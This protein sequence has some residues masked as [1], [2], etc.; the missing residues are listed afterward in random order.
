MLR[1]V[2]RQVPFARTGYRAIRCFGVGSARLAVSLIL[3]TI[4]RSAWLRGMAFDALKQDLVLAP[5]PESF[6]VS[7]RDK[8]IGRDIYANAEFDFAK[9]RTAIR[10]A[11]LSD[12]N[13]DLLFVDIGANIGPI[14]IPVI[15]RGLAARALAIEPEPLNRKL[16][17]ANAILNDVSDRIEVFP[18]A[19]GAAPG[20][21][22]FELSDRNFGDH[23]IRSKV[24]ASEDRYREAE[25]DTVEVEMTTLDRVLEPETAPNVLLWLDTQGYEGFVLKGATATLKQRHPMVLEFW[26]YGMKRSGSFESLLECLC[27][28]DY[29]TFVDLEDTEATRTALTGAALTELYE[30]LGEDGRFTDI[31][32]L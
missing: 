30:R 8:A 29:E 16:L 20:T 28:S 4:D 13:A 25:R 1:E 26:P 3:N 22:T 23:R 19:L 6:V 12:R 5:G 18:V 7:T 15:K 14:C 9:L 2:L 27:E 11:G 24:E 17:V 10:L 31:L 32:V 21:V